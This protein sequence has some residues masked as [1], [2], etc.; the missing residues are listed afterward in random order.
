MEGDVVAI[1]RGEDKFSWA[2]RRNAGEKKGKLNLKIRAGWVTWWERSSPDSPFLG[3]YE[4]ELKF[5]VSSEGLRKNFTQTGT[6]F[7]FL[8]IK[9]QYTF[10]LLAA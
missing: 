4:D 10:L 3:V 1:C 9:R 8:K 7:A 5:E 6:R 2:D